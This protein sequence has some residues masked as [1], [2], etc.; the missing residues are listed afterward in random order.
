MS[1]KNT[2]WRLRAAGFAMVLL[3]AASVP[4]PV[5]ALD[6]TVS[7]DFW[8]TTE[9]VNAAPSVESGVLPVAVDAVAKTE[10]PS[11]VLSRFFST[12]CRGFVLFLQ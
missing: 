6:N 8:D 5:H 11:N 7:N 9:Y 4:T 2:E 3:A 12:V 1:P 10:K